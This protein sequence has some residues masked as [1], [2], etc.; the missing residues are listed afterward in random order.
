MT[1]VTIERIAH[2]PSMDRNGYK[3]GTVVEG[4]G[5]RQVAQPSDEKRDSLRNKQDDCCGRGERK[6]SYVA[7]RRIGGD[8]AILRRQRLSTHIRSGVRVR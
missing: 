6:A 7:G 3:A 5:G 2:R 8:H 4:L 1:K